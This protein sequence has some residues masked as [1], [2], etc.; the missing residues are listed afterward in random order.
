MKKYTSIICTLA[1]LLMASAV[2]FV[3]CSKDEE[4]TVSGKFT[5]TV[6]ASK[7]T[8][9]TKH[10]EEGEGNTIIA[11]WKTGESVTV[12][13]GETYLGRLGVT[14][15]GSSTTLTGTIEGEFAVNDVLTLKF[16]DPID[17][18]NEQDGT[19]ENIATHFDHAV[20]TVTVTS[21]SG[22]SSSMPSDVTSFLTNSG[23]SWMVRRTP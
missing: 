20:A 19:L 11:T 12:D 10:L 13:K 15:E 6:N 18:D 17:E 5:L 4:P 8:P 7:G 9:A 16:L 3:S 1:V 2:T 14:T 23:W 22:S 21:I